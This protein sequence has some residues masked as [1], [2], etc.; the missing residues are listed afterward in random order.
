[1]LCLKGKG[2]RRA[3][4]PTKAK[5]DVLAHHPI[6]TSGAPTQSAHDPDDATIA[7]FG[8]VRR[9]LRA[10]KRRHTLGTH[11]HHSLWATEIWWSTKPPDGRGIRP[12]K[13][14][15]YIEQALYLLWRQGAKVVINLQV[16][17]PAHAASQV[18]AGLYFHDGKPKPALTAFRFPLVTDRTSR[19]AVR[20]WG[21][22]PA[23][24][25]LV[26]ERKHGGGWKRV[27][28]LKVGEGKVFQ[29]KLHLSGKA[30][31]RATVGG[32]HSLAWRQR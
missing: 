2:L 23:G 12:A 29:T 20:A 32:E 18:Y 9:I 24:G 16:R 15:R 3:K 31:L 11:G 14:A 5:F 19:H 8:Q 4:C 6:N 7:D 28:S 17:D 22:A 30:H 21:K 1:V 25:R 27:K 26:I 10:A 13:Q